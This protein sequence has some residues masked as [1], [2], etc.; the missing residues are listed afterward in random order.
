MKIIVITIQL[1]NQNYTYGNNII[2]NG[3][4]KELL[5]EIKI[6]TKEQRKKY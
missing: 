6:L 1:L 4:D 5:K 3:D 2:S